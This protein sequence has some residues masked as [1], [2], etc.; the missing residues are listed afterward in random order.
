M[1]KSTIANIKKHALEDYPREACGLLLITSLGKEQYIP[2]R[3][4]A[5]GNDH[6]I[7]AAEDYA[8]AERQ[9]EVVGVVHS[10][11]EAASKP[12]E[13]DLVACEASELPWYIVSVYKDLISGQLA[14]SDLNMV[15]PIGYE[16]PLVGREFALATLDCYSLILD[17]FSREHGIE[18]PD[19]ERE[20]RA[21]TWWEDPANES[22]YLKHFEAAGFVE[23][24]DGP[25]ENDV[26]LMEVQTKAGPNHAGV[27]LKDGLML[28]HLYG[29]LST[30]AIYGGYWAETTRRVVRHKELIGGTQ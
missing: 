9:G 6:F 7:M 10:H 1:K 17:F 11:P 30:R 24:S 18:L 23:V 19:F 27:M 26:I 4:K 13:A 20:L 21:T 25:Q 12:S 28:H 2:C 8:D 3:N 15:E 16:A 14:T 29:R 22:L 5:V